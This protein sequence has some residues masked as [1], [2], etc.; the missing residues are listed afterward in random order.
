[1]YREIHKKA[2]RSVP[3]KLFLYIHASLL[4]RLFINYFPEREHFLQIINEWTT[5]D[6]LR[7]FL[8]SV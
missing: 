2:K 5:I 4:Y 6:L 1:M 8:E 3:K 7:L